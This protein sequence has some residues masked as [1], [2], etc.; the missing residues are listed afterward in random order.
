MTSGLKR[1]LNFLQ[2]LYNVKISLKKIKPVKM[3]ALKSGR[4]LKYRK[5]QN[6]ADFILPE[7]DDFEIIEILTGERK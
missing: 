7:L 4:N 6:G 2:V 5:T 3:H 1:P